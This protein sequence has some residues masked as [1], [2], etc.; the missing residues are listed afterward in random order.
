MPCHR[1]GA[2]A[3]DPK[4]GPSAWRRGVQADEQ[5]LVCPDCQRDADWTAGLDRCTECASPAL[6][7]RLGET[8]CRSCGH[9]GS[10]RPASVAPPRAIPDSGLRRDV[11]A[12]LERIFR[13][14]P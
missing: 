5:V 9:V 4:R 6:F 13:T 2:R 14:E 12:A 7:R 3:T 8:V 1:C 11:E 10:G